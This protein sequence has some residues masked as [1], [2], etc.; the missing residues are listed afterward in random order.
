MVTLSGANADINNSLGAVSVMIERGCI[1]VSFFIRSG[2]PGPLP[3]TLPGA[4]ASAVASVGPASASGRRWVGGVA[5]L[6]SVLLLPSIPAAWDGGGW[7]GSSLPLTLAFEAFARP[8][9]R[10]L[11]YN[12]KPHIKNSVCNKH[13]AKLAPCF[14]R[15]HCSRE[16]G[17]H[18]CQGKGLHRVPGQSTPKNQSAVPNR[19]P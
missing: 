14:W 3:L 4:S 6:S 8:D 19:Y 7:G 12:K 1:R 16:V 2:S 15:L 9:F 10:A 17:L 18:I 5:G 11:A 13:R